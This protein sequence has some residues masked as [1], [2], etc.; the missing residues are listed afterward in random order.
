[1]NF[2]GLL[3]RNL[4]ETLRDPI[5]ILLA[6]GFPVFLLV[7]FFI[8]DKS[9]ELDIAMFSPSELTPGVIVFGYSMLMMS[10]GNLICSDRNSSLFSR[11]RTLPIRTADYMIAYAVPFLLI[12]IGQYVVTYAIAF[13]FGLCFTPHVF[14]NFL[15]LF[16]IAIIF[17]SLG[18]LMGFTMNSAQMVG[19]GNGLITVIAIISG[20]WFPITL[21]GGAFETIATIF[22]FY[23]AV[24][25][26]RTLL[27]GA[28]FEWYRVYILVA[29]AVIIPAIS[30]LVTARRLKKA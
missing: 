19:I 29:Y 25:L 2:K 10:E 7:L 13:F 21:V 24:A 1:M 14:T 17:V 26:S 9:V 28:D 5:S 16:P 11:F 6:L 12:A 4:I 30:A 18:M 22:P 20:A 23:N 8:I 15:L 27:N 3:K